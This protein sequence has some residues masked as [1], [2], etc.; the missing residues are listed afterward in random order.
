MLIPCPECQKPVS[1]AAPTCPGC[2]FV[3]SP[4]IVAEQKEKKRKGEQVG[5]VVFIGF[6][7]ILFLVCSGAFSSSSSSSG[8]SSPASSSSSNTASTSGPVF[9]SDK[10][11]LEWRYQS[12]LPMTEED[13]QYQLS[14]V[15]E[16]F[17]TIKASER[18]VG[19]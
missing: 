9:A 5:A 13:K 18:S 6:A 1:E 17:D 3:L 19:Y 4:A 15:K 11:R 2:G 12:G 14:K 7:V 8:S 16:E 10:E